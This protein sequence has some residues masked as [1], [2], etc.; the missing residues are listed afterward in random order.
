ME[1]KSELWYQTTPL[2]N[3]SFVRSDAQHSPDLVGTKWHQIIPPPK[4]KI[5]LINLTIA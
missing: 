2:N 1:K 5:E 4:P 3:Y